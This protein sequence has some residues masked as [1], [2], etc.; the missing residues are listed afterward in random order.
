ME[1]SQTNGKKWY[2]RAWAHLTRKVQGSA[3]SWQVW[4]L[5]VFTLMLTAFA[6]WVL[7]TVYAMTH[8]IFA[9]VMVACGAGVFVRF[10]RM[11]GHKRPERWSFAIRS[12]WR[13]GIWHMVCNND[14]KRSHYTW[15]RFLLANLLIFGALPTVWAASQVWAWFGPQIPPISWPDVLADLL[16]SVLA[17]GGVVFVLFL[18]WKGI[19]WVK[20]T[21]G[22]RRPYEDK[23]REFRNAIDGWKSALE[24]RDA[25]IKKL[26][27]A[28]ADALDA[29]A[30]AMVQIEE[31]KGARSKDAQ[32]VAAV[33]AKHKLKEALIRLVPEES[34][35]KGVIGRA[36]ANLHPELAEAPAQT[37]VPAA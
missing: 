23:L 37:D 17:I 22:L 8:P 5:I 15:R 36:Y 14:T 35:R 16:L 4:G 21:V 30:M 1:D 3:V 28:G 13:P 26:R 7:P 2:M 12:V 25:T 9:W 19:E 31:E 18:A 27:A 29:I 24:E 10:V 32:I 20:D 34:G 6:L 11:I 33:V